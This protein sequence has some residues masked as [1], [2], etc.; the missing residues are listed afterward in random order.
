MHSH[1][2]RHSSSLLWPG[3]SQTISVQRR[4]MASARSVGRATF[5]FEVGFCAKYCWGEAASRASQ[6]L[7]RSSCAGVRPGGG[8]GGGGFAP[9]G[10]G[11]AAAVVLE[12]D[13]PLPVNG[14]ESAGTL[15]TV[16]GQSSS[17]A[18]KFAAS[19]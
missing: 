4:A 9:L 5:F 19:E 15:Q 13:V 6:S 17:G 2:L 8:G 16:P 18:S 10:G 7:L 11:A 14:E 1:C 12:P 3:Q